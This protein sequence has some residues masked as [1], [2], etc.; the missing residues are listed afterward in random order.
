MRIVQL[1][2]T[3]EIGGLERL[4]VDLAVQ[5]KIE[6]EQPF[7]YCTRHAGP[8]AAEAQAAEI[9]IHTFGKCDGFSL[10][11]IYQIAARLLRDRPDV[12][13][14]HN[15]L[16]LHYAIAA[17]KL[18]R[19]PAVVNTRHSG[20]LRW[21]TH[22]EKIWRRMVPWTDAVVFVSDGVRDY[23]VAKDDLSRTRTRVIYNGIPLE[24]FSKCRARPGGRLPHIRFGTV[25]RL[26]SVKDHVTLVRAFARVRTSWPDAELHIL[27][28]GPCRSEIAG[29]AAS[30]GIA[31]HV[32]LRSGTDVGP[33]LAGLDLFVMSS[34]DEGLPLVLQEAM[35]AGL[36]IVSTRLRGLT[37]IAPEG[38]V[39][40]YCAPGQPD[41]LGDLMLQI[42]RRCD[43]SQIGATAS[44]LAASFG[45][46]K[47]WA[48]YRGLFEEIL[49]DG[50][51]RRLAGIASAGSELR[52]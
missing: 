39:A 28:E 23:F 9:P 8:L 41:Q 2:P 26:A 22:C 18:A 52:R 1:L 43:L 4:A 21:D 51:P 15:P 24:K 46:E 48:L 49:R 35:A 34:L 12:I 47:T 14:A 13:H 6:G 50:L 25:G 36:P 44:R 37:E 32:R 17:A 5:Q 42:A 11:L 10:R 31:D 16:V 33:F 30:L 38:T 40:W 3:L 29:T 7:L 20:N 27:G 19:V 45:I